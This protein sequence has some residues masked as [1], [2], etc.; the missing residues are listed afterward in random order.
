MKEYIVI[1]RIEQNIAICEKEDGTFIEIEKE[2]LPN[3]IEEGDC[4]ILVQG[5]W[6]VDKEETE[7]R[8]EQIQGMLD[9]LL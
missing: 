2:K 6:Q 3:E 4:L 9:E 5:Q 1:D 8:W 7:R